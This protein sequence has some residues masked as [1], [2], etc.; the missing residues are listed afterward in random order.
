MVEYMLGQGYKVRAV[1]LDT[2]DISHLGS[3][4]NLEIVEGNL[5]DQRVTTELVKDIDIVYHLA[6]LHLS[7]ASSNQFYKDNNYGGTKKLL[8][9]SHRQGVSR[10]VYVSTVGVMKDMGK[11]EA[12]EQSPIQP[13]TIYEKT[14]W[15]AEEYA[16]DYY[17]KTGYPVTVV[18]P[19]FV[20]GPTV[21]PDHK[22]V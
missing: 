6:S 21:F 20:Y 19:S 14:K 11:E 15:M 2:T 9:E 18:R 7:I 22:I 16:M 13:T 4:Q 17:H 10:F 8:E 1:D 5:L 3:N 12:D